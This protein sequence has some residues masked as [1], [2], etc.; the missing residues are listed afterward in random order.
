MLLDGDTTI[1]RKEVNEILGV[2]EILKLINTYNAFGAPFSARSKMD[3]IF[4]FHGETKPP[5][6]KKFTS[7]KPRFA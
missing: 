6:E 4:P 1:E 3:K 5:P 7:K 2:V